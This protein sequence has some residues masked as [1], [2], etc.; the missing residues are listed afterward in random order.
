MSH[1]SQR[2]VNPSTVDWPLKATLTGSGFSGPEILLAAALSTTCYPLT[3]N[4]KKEGE[5]LVRNS[6]DMFHVRPAFSLIVRHVM[7]A[8]ACLHVGILKHFRN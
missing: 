3:F 8:C 4:P 1:P 5:F 7:V 6:D 2:Q